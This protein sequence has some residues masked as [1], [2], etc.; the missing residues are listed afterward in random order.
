MSE[1][2]DIPQET[3]E[4]SSAKNKI[5]LGVVLALLGLLLR[6]WLGWVFVE[7]G[8]AKT[9]NLAAFYNAAHA[10]KLLPPM[11]T[12]LYATMLPWVE[13]LAGGLL[14]LGFLTRWMSG[15]I[16]LMLVSFIVA[17]GWALYMGDE[18]DC[19]CFVGGVVEPVTWGLMGRDVLM[20]I[21]SVYLVYRP[22]TFL[23][24]DGWLDDTP[25]EGETLA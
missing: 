17:I 15:T 20:L 19:G 4:S 16:G 8:W 22:T 12:Q 24:L 21:A 23:S 13:I 7:S 25:D 10:Y 6:L 18:I 3:I 11:L 2:Q 9:Q 1:Q 14:L 5:K